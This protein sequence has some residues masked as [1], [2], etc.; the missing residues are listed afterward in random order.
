MRTMV[1]V[2]MASALA[3]CRSRTEFGPCIGLNAALNRTGDSTLIYE[4]STR[5]IFWGLVGFEFLYPP[6]KVALDEVQCPTRRRDG[7]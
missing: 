2:L 6:I 7:R 4:V 5:N 1:V 3:G